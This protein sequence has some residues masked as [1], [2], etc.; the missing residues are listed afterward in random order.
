MVGNRAECM[1]LAALVQRKAD[2]EHDFRPP[3]HDRTLHGVKLT[4]RAETAVDSTLGNAIR[5]HRV[6]AGKRLLLRKSASV[7]TSATRVPSMIT[8]TGPVTT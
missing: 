1:E 5:H 8:S 4:Q 3:L 7:V 2:V 6:N